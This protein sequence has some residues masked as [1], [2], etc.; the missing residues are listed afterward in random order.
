MWDDPNILFA[1][2]EPHEFR[3]Y[4]KDD[5]SIWAVVDEVD[6]H[7]LIRWRWNVKLC[8]SQI[9]YLRRAV[10]VNQGGVRLKTY[11]VY[12][13]VDVMQATGIAP[14]SEHHR[15]VDHR[16]GNSLD[17]RRANLRWATPRMNAR[18][19]FGSHSHELIE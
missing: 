12:L 7:R 18:N 9:P 8:R 4:G 3:I 17:C 5:A 2:S 10:G 13:H 6:Y 15:I 14:P 16:N 1:F 11:S 19:K